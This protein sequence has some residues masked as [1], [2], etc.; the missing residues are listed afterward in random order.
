MSLSSGDEVPQIFTRKSRLRPGEFLIT[1]AKRLLQQYLPGP[2]SCSAA[3][4]SLLDDLIRAGKQIRRYGKTE[5]FGYLFAYDDHLNVLLNPAFPRRDQSA[6]RRV[7]NE[8][9]NTPVH[10]LQPYSNNART[11]SKKQLRQIANSKGSRA[12]NGHPGQAHLLSSSAGGDP[13]GPTT[14][15]RRRVLLQ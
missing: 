7:S 3:K 6:E 4:S 1:T 9:R 8:N 10:K 5:Q 13:P 11:H 2:N 12:S 14:A 15:G